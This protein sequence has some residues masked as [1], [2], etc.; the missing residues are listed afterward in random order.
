MWLVDFFLIVNDGALWHRDAVYQALSGY[1]GNTLIYC[2]FWSFLWSLLIV[3][4][5]KSP[6]LSFNSLTV[7]C[8]YEVALTLNIMF[9]IHVTAAPTCAA[10]SQC[11]GDVGP[12]IE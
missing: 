3:K 7:F 6:D 1:I 12:V 8:T 11:V 2:W 4:I 10:V 9:Y 5:R